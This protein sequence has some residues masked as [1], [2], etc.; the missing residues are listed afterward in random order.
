MTEKSTN[1]H[2]FFSLNNLLSKILRLFVRNRIHL[3][4]L[5]FIVAYLA[6][7]PGLI[8]R[9]VDKL[10]KPVDSNLSLPAPSDKISNSLD[11]H[12]D[13]VID[14]QKLQQILGW[15]FL[16]EEPDQAKFDK[17]LV[18]HSSDRIYYF[19]YETMKRDD[20]QD[21]FQNLGLDIVNSGFRAYISADNIQSGSYNIG[22]VF[23]EK[24][25]QGAFYTKTNYYLKRTPNTVS[26][27]KEILP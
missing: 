5:V 8:A 3:F 9:F 4:V 6:F 2:G 19:Q 18:L 16:M 14:H 23:T 13:V 15:A 27:E 22:F 24:S 1:S 12:Q 25:G 21:Y 11:S 10:G 17:Y 7:A 26:I 20:V